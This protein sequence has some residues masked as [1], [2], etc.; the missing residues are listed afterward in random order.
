ML[1]TTR[2]EIEKDGDARTLH[3]QVDSNANEDTKLINSQDKIELEQNLA[4]KY[5]MISCLVESNSL[6]KDVWAFWNGILCMQA[7]QFQLAIVSGLHVC[8]CGSETQ[9]NRQGRTLEAL[10]E[11]FRCFAWPVKPPSFEA[12]NM[13]L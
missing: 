3:R 9:T 2:V 13:I 8:F 10:E 1:G 6:S 4:N 7:V 11:M 12:K 5:P